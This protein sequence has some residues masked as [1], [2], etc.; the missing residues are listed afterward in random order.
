[1]ATDVEAFACATFANAAIDPEL[2]R[3]VDFGPAW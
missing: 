3:T 2:L 1:V